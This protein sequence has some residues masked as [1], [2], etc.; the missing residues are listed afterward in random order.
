VAVT[1]RAFQNWANGDNSKHWE[2]LSGL[3]QTETLIKGPFAS[4]PKG[5]TKIKQRPAVICDRI[6]HRT[7]LPERTSQTGI[8]KQSHLWK[9]P[10]KN[11]S[12]THI[13]CKCES[14]A[15]VRFK[16]L[17]HYFM[18]PGNYHDT[19]NNESPAL[20]RKCQLDREWLRRGS[21]IDL[22]GGTVRARWLL[23]KSSHIPT[24]IVIIVPLLHA[25]SH[26]FAECTGC[27]VCRRACHV[28]TM[29]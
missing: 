1:K 14:I 8:N 25:L 12:A 19:T 15:Y 10:R 7:L 23:T 11:E 17:G 3:R 6:T 22:E 4:K 16:Q 9:L 2:S 13:L 26:D 24:C 27:K 28:I 5:A 29:F 21:T 20:H 18:E